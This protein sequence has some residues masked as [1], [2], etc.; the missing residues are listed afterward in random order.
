M[1]SPATLLRRQLERIP[2]TCRRCGHTYPDSILEQVVESN[3][4]ACPL[5]VEDILERF[6]R[7]GCQAIGLGSVCRRRSA[8]C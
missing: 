2:L 4:P 3:P 1:A 5:T 8:S 6:R 7:R